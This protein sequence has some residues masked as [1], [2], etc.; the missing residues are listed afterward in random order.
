MKQIWDAIVIG[1][2]PAGALTAFELAKKRYTVLLI[3]K[4][5]FPRFKVCGSCLNQ[6]AL[7]CLSQAGLDHLPSLKEAANVNGLTIYRAGIRA[8][9]ALPTGFAVLRSQFD[10]DLATKAQSAGAIFL[11]GR[12]AIVRSLGERTDTDFA[13]V[14]VEAEDGWQD[15]KCKAVVVAD[16]LNGTSLKSFKHLAPI[17]SHNSKVGLGA[18]LRS[19]GQTFD[20]FAAN[21]I[22]MFSSAQGYLG[23][24][25]LHDG[26]LDLACALDKELLNGGKSPNQFAFDLISANRVCPPD[27]L[28]EARFQGT[29]R[30]SR[31]RPK[32]AEERLF[33][34]GDASAYT[35][36]FTGQGIAWALNSALLAANEITLA[37]DATNRAT[38]IQAKNNWQ[39]LTDRKLR[40]RQTTS[41]LLARALSARP[42]GDTLLKVLV[43]YPSLSSRIAN[44]VVAEINGATQTKGISRPTKKSSFE[45]A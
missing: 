14:L 22:H 31:R 24:V 35:E 25:R 23:I 18:V 1:A 27:G 41:R 32:V 30:L 36:P 7:S 16:G 40:P 2:G 3:D 43:R 12:Q 5:Q 26:S 11:S 45:I 34:L 42:I 39:N 13:S 6:D 21:R 17:V 38:L 9:I 15:M 33:I 44:F 19:Q 29:D 20:R 10:Y 8:S 28:F 37:I 4:S